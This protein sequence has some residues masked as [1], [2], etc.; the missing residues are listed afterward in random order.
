MS[1]KYQLVSWMSNNMQHRNSCFPHELNDHNDH[2]CE[3]EF[4]SCC[5]WYSMR[6]EKSNLSLQL[7]SIINS[8]VISVSRSSL[9]A[10][11]P[12]IIIWRVCVNDE[13]F[14]W[15]VIVWIPFLQGSLQLDCI[16]NIFYGTLFHYLRQF[17]KRIELN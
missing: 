13:W 3:H 12:Y 2:V 17:L 10:W 6:Q 11:D 15:H 16:L 1:F 5:C 8:Q 14:V 9:Q 4:N 7:S